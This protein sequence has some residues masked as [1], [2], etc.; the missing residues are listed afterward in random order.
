MRKT[1]VVIGEGRRRKQG[2]VENMTRKNK[3]EGWK[4]RGKKVRE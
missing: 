2:E 3:S 4:K 1:K